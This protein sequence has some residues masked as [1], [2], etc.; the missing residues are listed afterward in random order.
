MSR[1]GSISCRNRSERDIMMPTGTPNNTLNPVQTNMIDSVCRATSRWSITP[2]N[3]KTDA[4]KTVMLTVRVASQVAKTRSGIR[5]HQGV[6][7]KAKSAPSSIQ[8]NGCVSGSRTNL[9]L[10]LMERK[11]CSTLIVMSRVWGNALQAS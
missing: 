1:T 7:M 4:T 3:R 2:K 10:S 9:R 8:D 11:P 5:I 6:A